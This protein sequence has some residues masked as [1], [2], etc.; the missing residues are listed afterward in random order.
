MLYYYWNF[1]YFSQDVLRFSKHFKIPW[2]Y[3]IVGTLHLQ[4]MVSQVTEQTFSIV[5]FLER[6]ERFV[7]TSRELVHQFQATYVTAHCTT[8]LT[9]S[10]KNATAVI[11]HK[12]LS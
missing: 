8:G 12:K 10:L 11:S 6:E 1:H 2:F 4:W 9:S 7:C 5:D 3:M